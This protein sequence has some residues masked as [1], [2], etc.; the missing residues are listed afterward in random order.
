MRHERLLLSRPQS[1]SM[2]F[3]L[4]VTRICIEFQRVDT[5]W[6]KCGL[7]SPERCQM[8]IIYNLTFVLHKKMK[9]V[10]D[11]TMKWT[12]LFH[13]NSDCGV[14][15]WGFLEN[16][17]PRR[18][19]VTEVFQS[20]KTSDSSGYGDVEVLFASDGS[21]SSLFCWLSVDWMRCHLSGD[22]LSSWLAN[23][24]DFVMG[25]VIGFFFSAQSILMWY[26]SVSMLTAAINHI[27]SLVF[28]G[29]EIQLCVSLFASIR[30]NLLAASHRCFT[31]ISAGFHLINPLLLLNSRG[32]MLIRRHYSTKTGTAFIVFGPFRP[33]SYLTV[34]D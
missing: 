6:W 34:D 14:R 32:T 15:I 12:K 28:P 26:F 7:P 29:K 22:L 9:D 21:L 17:T 13:K 16:Y 27:E 24:L 4:P 30:R 8:F 20:R 23:R 33:V 1:T 10:F 11:D 19:D 2:R 31:S 25:S 18:V 3:T 5:F